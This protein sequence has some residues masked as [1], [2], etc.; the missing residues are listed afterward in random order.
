MPNACKEY[1][2]PSKTI[3]A[4]GFKY[5]PCKIW[6]GNAHLL[7][8]HLLSLKIVDFSSFNFH[9]PENF[10]ATEI[11]TCSYP[12]QENSKNVSYGFDFCLI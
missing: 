5:A 4:Y 8:Q 6:K 7:T 3:D 10:P 9:F 12:L 1:D 11:Q 2:T